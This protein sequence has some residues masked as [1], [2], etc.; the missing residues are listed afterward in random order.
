MGLD[1]QGAYFYQPYSKPSCRYL[2]FLPFHIRPASGTSSEAQAKYL[3]TLS[4]RLRVNTPDHI[5]L[6]FLLSA[7]TPSLHSFSSTNNP[8]FFS[9]Y[10]AGKANEVNH[11]AHV[12]YFGTNLTLFLKSRDKFSKASWVSRQTTSPL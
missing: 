3:P 8:F 1:S 5:T 9:H 7:H 10:R 11:W 2:P 12:I 6:H 4:L